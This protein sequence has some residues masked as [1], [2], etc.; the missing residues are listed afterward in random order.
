MKTLNNYIDQSRTE[1]LDAM[2]AF[3]A[4]SSEQ[5]DQ[6]KQ[7]GVVYCNLGA[8]LIAPKETAKALID[9]LEDVTRSGIKQDLADNGKQAIIQRELDNHE[10]FYTGDITDCVD[11][12]SGYEITQEDIRKVFHGGSLSS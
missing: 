6:N 5:F 9:G 4:F 1:L 11:A 7:E 2:G 3:F 10:C 8:G 12:L